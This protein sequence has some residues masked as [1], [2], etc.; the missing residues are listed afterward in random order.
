M[1]KNS[2]LDKQCKDLEVWLRERRYSEELVRKQILKARKFSRT[3]LLNKQRKKEN[4]KKLVLNITCH[5]S[6]AMLKILKIRIHLLLT[7]DNEHIKVFRNVA[8]IEFR[9]AKS[10][11]NILVRAKKPQ[12]KNEGLCGPC[13]GP[14]Q[15]WKHIVPTRNF[16]SFITKSTY[17]IRLENLNCRS[18]NSVH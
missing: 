2:V 7:P 3:E 8:I 18:K 4:E 12:I 9:R 11:K 6:V 13:K 10:L 15:I 16:A 17:E 1:V 5:P 14:T